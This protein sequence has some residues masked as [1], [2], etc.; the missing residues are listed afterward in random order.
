MLGNSKFIAGLLVGAAAGAAIAILLN[1]EKGKEIIEDLKTA[2]NKAGD[3]LKDA[4]GRLEAEL[5]AV[6]EKGKEYAENL[7]Q[8]VR[9]FTA[10]NN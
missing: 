1:S 7:G 2:A 6:V 3:E 4:A 10:L 9:D 8:Q 5:A